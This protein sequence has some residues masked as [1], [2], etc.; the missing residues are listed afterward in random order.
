VIGS[1]H[2]DRD[3]VV[4]DRDVHG[5]PKGSFEPH[6]RPAA[7]S[8]VVDDELARKTEARPEDRA[9]ASEQFLLAHFGIFFA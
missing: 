9:P 7:A 3:R 2:G 1:V 8:E 5:T 6:G 4:I